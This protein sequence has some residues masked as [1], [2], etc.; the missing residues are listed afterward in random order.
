MRNY[1]NLFSEF[2]LSFCLV[3][4]QQHP[5][6]VQCLKGRFA[7]L[8]NLKSII[9]PWSLKGPGPSRQCLPHKS[10]VEVE[11]IQVRW[12]T[13]PLSDSPLSYYPSISQTNFPKLS[14]FF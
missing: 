14:G 5:S 13:L 6:D 11:Q 7:Q 9:P 4:Q 12:I 2:F 10:N 3:Y 8:S 1:S